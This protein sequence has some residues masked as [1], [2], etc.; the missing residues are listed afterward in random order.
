MDY[1]YSMSMN[2]TDSVGFLSPAEL[3]GEFRTTLI[4]IA[5]ISGLALRTIWEFI[6]KKQDGEAIVFDKKFFYTAI[7]AFVGAGLPA[8]AL[9][10][11]ATATFESFAGSYGLIGGFM[12]T[13]FL[14]YGGNHFANYVLKRVEHT[15]ETKLIESERFNKIIE[16]KVEA[17][18]EEKLKTVTVNQKDPEQTKL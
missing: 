14:V 4:F 9:M 15:T 12:I 5:V 3:F 1:R 7:A 17:K 2:G 16:S 13:M 8:L 6:G 10:P 11:A 18:V